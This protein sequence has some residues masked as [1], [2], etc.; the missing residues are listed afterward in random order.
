M[1]DDWLNINKIKL[2]VQFSY[3]FVQFPSSFE[4]FLFSFSK[5][6]GQSSKN[7]CLINEKGEKFANRLGRKNCK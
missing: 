1:Y 4:Q 7:R 2:T 5:R 3:M 6:V